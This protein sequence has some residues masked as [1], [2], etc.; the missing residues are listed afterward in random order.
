MS[1]SAPQS[2]YQIRC[3]YFVQGRAEPCEV[4]VVL[5]RQLS[6]DVQVCLRSRYCTSG[7]FIGCPLF[8]GIQQ[9]L[10]AWDRMRELAAR[11]C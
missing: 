2:S 4:V 8:R 10:E 9:R 7:L 1:G 6:C 3:P 11:A 5:D